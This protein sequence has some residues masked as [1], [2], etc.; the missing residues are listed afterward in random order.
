MLIGSSGPC[1]VFGTDSMRKPRL[2]A[3][4]VARVLFVAL[5]SAL[6]SCGK[7]P[8]RPFPN[9]PPFIPQIDVFPVW[10]N[11]GTSIAYFRRF[12]SADGPPGVYIISKWGGQPRLVVAG[13]Y[14]QYRFAPDDRQ[15]VA[16]SQ[17][18]ELVLIDVATGN[19]TRPFYTDNLVDT[20]CWSPSG[21][22]ILYL[23]DGPN[24]GEPADSGG[25][26][27]FNL[28]TGVD[29]ALTDGSQVVRG[30]RPTWLPTG[31]IAMVALNGY[32]PSQIVAVDAHTGKKRT[33]YTS[34][35]TNTF[36]LFT[37]YNRP[38]TGAYGVFF[39]DNDEPP[40]GGLFLVRP[41]GSE[42]RRMPLTR[43]SI[44]GYGLEAFSPDGEEWV[45]GGFD[46]VDSL[47]I[48]F[49]R[50]IDDLAGASARQ[51]TRYSPPSNLTA[52][53][54][55]LSSPPGSRNWERR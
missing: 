55:V 16:L 24:I 9:P 8:T 29:R 32:A 37:W 28:T 4:W 34:R 5:L 25:V 13:D 51:L 41:D 53:T 10:S 30:F 2:R 14:G 46:P 33:L 35:L 17:A 23:K 1:H 31:Q 21:D 38:S 36:Y 44:L 54:P 19:V 22:E 45:H 20:P 11:D 49:V 18:L 6:A 26:H 42:L 27:I 50:R 7:I 15:L 39:T 40:F 48:L 47:G 12:L 52:A 43:P 3:S